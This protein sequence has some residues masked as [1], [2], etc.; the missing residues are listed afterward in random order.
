MGRAPMRNLLTLSILANAL[1]LAAWMW[2]HREAGRSVQSTADSLHATLDAHP[3][4]P[5]MQASG[6]PAGGAST[7]GATN[8]FPEWSTFESADYREYVKR[9]RAAGVPED[10]VRDLIT[11]DV[12]KAFGPRAV[13]PGRQSPFAPR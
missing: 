3:A 2:G 7:S 1:L 10:I 11:A 5:R 4:R 6:A 9:L 8:A 13:A 12:R